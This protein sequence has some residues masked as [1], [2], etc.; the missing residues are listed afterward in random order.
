MALTAAV[1]LCAAGC[2]RLEPETTGVER[3]LLCQ[4]RSGCRYLTGGDSYWE[5][6]DPAWNA[7]WL[8]LAD[9]Y[10]RPEEICFELSEDIERDVFAVDESYHMVW[11]R[12]LGSGRHSVPVTE[13]MM[14][15]I[16]SVREEETFRP[17]GKGMHPR[18]E[19]PLTG[20]RMS[21][22]GDS[23]SAFTGYIPWD[24][25]A[26][27]SDANF[28]A[29]SMWWAVLAENTGME[30]C[31]INAISSSGVIVP[32]DAETDRLVTGNS[33]RCKNLPK[34]RGPG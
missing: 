26:Y 31:N 5:E 16:F 3:E 17:V 12:T 11:K 24:D 28:G 20:R 2:S 30:I 14:G 9:Q 33:D 32:E 22:I 34:R 19:T 8:T 7:Y 13:S 15:I 6:K 25:Y 29:S 10:S 27:Y 18:M 23:V 21:L 1:L 4:F